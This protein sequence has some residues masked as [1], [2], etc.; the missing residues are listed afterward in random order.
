MKPETIDPA[1]LS[2]LC[3]FCADDSDGVDENELAALEAAGL[4]LS[5][6]LTPNGCA[7]LVRALRLSEL[8]GK[9]LEACLTVA[10]RTS[11]WE[12]LDD[13]S[14]KRDAA[15]RAYEAAGGVV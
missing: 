4:V 2:L 11:Q 3:R 13:V 8:R 14:A 10:H 5:S 6:D 1:L 12:G 15:W 7:L 9:W